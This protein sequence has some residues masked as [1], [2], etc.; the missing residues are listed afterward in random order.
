[1]TA[2]RAEPV[3]L[4]RCVA[5]GRKSGGRVPVNPHNHRESGDGTFRYPRRHYIGATLCPGNKQE[6]EWL[7]PRTGKTKGSK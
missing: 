3:A 4:V 2:K 7:V 1:M 6:A 5:C